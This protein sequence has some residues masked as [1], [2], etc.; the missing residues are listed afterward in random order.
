VV[1]VVL[2]LG[3]SCDSGGPSADGERDGGASALSSVPLRAAE[4]PRGL[5]LDPAGTGPIDSLRQILP[6][7]SHFPNLQPVPDRVRDA[8]RDGF[9]RAFTDPKGEGAV[10]SSAVRFADPVSAASFLSYLRGLPVGGNAAAVEDVRAEGLG[11]E[12]YGWHLEVPESESSGYGWRA[13]DLVLTLSLAGPIGRAGQ[14]AALAL[15]A[16]IDGRLA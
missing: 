14:D 16:R 12:G 7:R 10:T 15:A 5:E 13:G 6:P 9:E 4:A 8:F 2:V 1:A 3:P 11:E